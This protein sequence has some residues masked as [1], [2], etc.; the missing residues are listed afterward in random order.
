MWRLLNEQ[1]FPANED[2]YYMHSLEYPEGVVA[3]RYGYK[4]H[5]HSE[6]TFATIATVGVT[7]EHAPRVGASELCAVCRAPRL[8]IFAVYDTAADA[9]DTS[10]KYRGFLPKE[11][12]WGDETRTC[13][14]GDRDVRYVVLRGCHP[15]RNELIMATQDNALDLIWRFGT[16]SPGGISWSSPAIRT[17][18]EKSF[19]VAYESQSGRCTHCPD[20]TGTPQRRTTPCG[21]VPHGCRT[22]RSQ[23][24]ISRVRLSSVFGW[25]PTPPPMRF[26]S[27]C[28]GRIWT[29]CSCCGMGLLSPTR[30]VIGTGIRHA[31][32]PCVDMAYEQ[33]SGDALKSGDTMSIRRPSTALWDGTTL[34][35]QI[36][37]PDFTARSDFMRNDCGSKRCQQQHRSGGH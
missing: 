31:G 3:G 13:D 18:A 27:R 8:S 7:G 11:G 24:L 33:A 21:T 30:G 20:E 25:C 16:A 37:L 19:D 10:P 4:V 6:T 23:S 35:P 22:R 17:T 15:Y 2:V 32:E 9:N 12:L 29:L 14:I 36:D 34:G 5:R 26:S 28:R 1:D